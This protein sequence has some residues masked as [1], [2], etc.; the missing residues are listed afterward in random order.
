M[1]GAAKKTQ[2][3]DNLER[4]SHQL[5]YPSLGQGLTPYKVLT[6]G[7]LTQGQQAPPETQGYPSNVLHVCIALSCCVLQRLDTQPLVKPA[8]L[9][10]CPPAL[11]L[12]FG[13]SGVAETRSSQDCH[14]DKDSS[15]SS[16]LNFPGVS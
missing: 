16:R 15:G 14:L 7:A 4:Q 5:H 9:F 2:G 3:W 11:H 13:V 6:T 1:K 12:Q 10:V 8:F